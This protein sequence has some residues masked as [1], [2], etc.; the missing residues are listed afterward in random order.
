MKKKAPVKSR[1]AL[2]LWLGCI[3][4]VIWFVFSVVIT[5]CT[6]KTMDRYL[7]KENGQIASNIINAAQ[8]QRLANDPEIQAETKDYWI[9]DG[10]NS[11]WLNN[12]FSGGLLRSTNHEPQTAVALY[13][14]EGHLLEK[15]ENAFYIRYITEENWYAQESDMDYDGV[16]K[17]LYDP[18]WITKTEISVI[19]RTDWIAMRFTGT[20]ENGI[21][22]ASKIEYINDDTFRDISMSHYPD[23]SYERH[24]R[25][26]DMEQ[27]YGLA[28]ETLMVSSY[29][30]EGQQVY[31][32]LNGDVSYYT[33]SESLVVE[34]VYY[35]DLM[36]YVLSI[37]DTSIYNDYYQN[38]QGNLMD[39][40]ITDS[41]MVHREEKGEFIPAYKVVAAVRYS[42]LKIAADS[43][44]Y[45]YI[46]SFLLQMSCA[47]LLW[48]VF[49][50]NLVFPIEAFNEAAE[51]SWGVIHHKQKRESRWYEVRQL[52]EHYQNT[53]SEIRKTRDE[54]SRV[55]AQL[56]YAQEAEVNRR[57]MT[58]H[59]AHELKTPIAIIHS[60]AEGLKEY[61]AE[62]KRDKYIDV[63]L[64]EVERTD[65][66]VLEMLDLSRLE[67][68]KV[69][70][71]RDDFSLIAL[72]K[73][74]FEKLEMVTQAKELQ[75]AYSFPKEFIIT[76]DEG[77]IAQVI[78]NFAT[79][80]IKYSPAR[81]RI[82]VQIQ[83][84]RR[85]T[86]FRIENDCE[87]LSEEALSKVWDTFYRTDEARSG[88][89]TGLGLSI[90]KNII[91]L[92]G[93]KCSVC[94]TKT[95]VAFTF[96]I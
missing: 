52:N 64:S 72:T 92:H 38:K 60:Y 44:L 79:N 77:R 47:A 43:L 27:R 88:G 13:D 24:Q 73:S 15:N 96:T 86:T 26:Q 55:T 28:W 20:L 30:A 87:P 39:M 9:W 41:W 78:E 40:L 61:I 66:M 3:F 91:E 50:R 8:L 85:G 17:T 37:K 6:A 54:L 35:Q 22:Q 21:L 11:D 65:N 16:A 49:V 94:N 2:A 1:W 42:P 71:S 93:G 19:Q 36:D 45:V 51:Q 10:V 84:S 32:T 70:L 18:S 76:A 53:R 14:G 31:Y 89:G 23:G 81:G 90:A 63:I 33:P 59:I 46:G 74:I 69:K 82:Q 75:V 12:S 58:S 95:G 5:W 56:Q 80:A 48:C 57:Q 83:T 4:T 25:I 29:D 7:E 68:G 34:N 62:E 67:A